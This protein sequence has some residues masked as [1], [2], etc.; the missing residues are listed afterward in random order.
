MPI[1]KS[2]IKRV[3]STK[4]RTARNVI[5]KRLLSEIIKVFTD[6]IAKKSFLEAQKLFPEL[7]KRIDLAVKKNIWHRNKGNR[8]KSQ[9]ARMLAAD[10]STNTQRKAISKKKPTEVTKKETSK[11]STAVKKN[12][13]KK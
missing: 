11:K 8:K 9:F 2:A 6:F 13:T 5:T 10:N 7:Q 1:I 3:R 12:Q 4:R